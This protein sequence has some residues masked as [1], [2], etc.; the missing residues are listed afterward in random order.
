MFNIVKVFYL[1]R[2]MFVAPELGELL[3]KLNDANDLSVGTCDFV[4]ED[5]LDRFPQLDIKWYHD[6]III[7][8][9]IYLR[10]RVIIFSP[11]LSRVQEF[12]FR[13]K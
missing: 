3:L 1:V 13:M 4:R 2:L 12:S 11:T 9:I 8:Y 6:G 5:T 10:I 7:N